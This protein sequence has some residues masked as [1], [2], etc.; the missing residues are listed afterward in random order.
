MCANAILSACSP[1]L[2]SWSLYTA[3]NLVTHRRKTYHRYSQSYTTKREEMHLLVLASRSR[4]SGI[5]C[6]RVNLK[7]PLITYFIISLSNYT[8]E[9]FSFRDGAKFGARAR[10]RDVFGK[11]L[12]ESSPLRSVRHFYTVRRC[13]IEREREK[14]GEKTRA[15][16][17][18]RECKKGQERERESCC[19][20]NP[21]CNTL[22]L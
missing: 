7:S 13:D 1:W 12:R 14:E 19:F 3:A 4:A 10:A 9:S 11:L 18:V 17:R 21:I 20:I 22:N 2:F 16:K 8:T 5:D 15:K 6:R